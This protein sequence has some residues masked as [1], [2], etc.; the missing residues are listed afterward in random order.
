MLGGSRVEGE[1]WFLVF[2]PQ[3]RSDGVAFR[4]GMSFCGHRVSS[5]GRTAHV[6]TAVCSD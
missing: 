3:K 2:W 4:V 1:P 5:C 6:G